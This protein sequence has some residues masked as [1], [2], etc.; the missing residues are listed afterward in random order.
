MLEIFTLGG[1]EYIVNVLN[2]VAAWTGGG[3]FRSLLQVVMVM[4]LTY[5]LIIV[6]FSLNWKAG[7]NWF[8]SATLMYACL[9]V[10]TTS[11][12]VTDKINPSLAPS[13]V[14]NVPIGLAALAS[15]T[16]QFG[17]WM[18]EQAELVFVMPAALSM[19]TN[20]FIYGTQLMEKSKLFTVSD[21]YLRANIVEYN[22]QCLM[23]D[24]LLGQKNI[25]TLAKSN[26]LLTDMGPGSA[27]RAQKWLDPSTGSSII[28]CQ[29][30]YGYI[31]AGMNA[32][33]E[34]GLGKIGQALFPK[35][36]AGDAL[37]K[38]KTDLT[39]TSAAFFGGAQD[40]KGAFN[41]RALAEAFME[42]RAMMGDDTAADSW[43]AL[44]ADV[45]ARNTYQSVGRQAM[46]WVPL[47]QIVLTV[48]F[49][50]MFPVIFPLFLM[51][52]S[53]PTALK[54]Y[55]AGFFYLAAWGP[56]Y[57]VLHMFVTQREIASMMT[58]GA[59][60]L[61]LSNLGGIDAVNNDAATIAGFLM[62]SVPF[63]AA[64]LARGAMAVASN[65]TSMLQPAQSAA[66]ASAIE[67]TTGNYA[68]GNV[69]F[70]N[71]TANTTQANRY[72][73][74]PSYTTGAA[75]SAVRNPEGTWERT[76]SDGQFSNTAFDTSGAMS[77]LPFTV[78][79]G[80]ARSMSARVAAGDSYRTAEAI[81]NVLS[82]STSIAKRRYEGN[83]VVYTDSEGNDLRLTKS[84]SET[85]AE[86]VSKDKVANKS[87]QTGRNISTND[88]VSERE[89]TT[90]T[91]SGGVGARGS[92]GG[93]LPGGGGE[94]GGGVSP[95][96]GQAGAQAN[97]DQQ[98][99]SQTASDS[100]TVSGKGVNTSVNSGTGT[101]VTDGTRVSTD[102]NTTNA[103]GEFSS[104]TKSNSSNSGVELSREERQS[105]QHEQSR[106]LQRAHT[107]D[108]IASMSSD[109]DSRFN[110]NILPLIE[111]QYNDLRNEHPELNLP[112]ISAVR[113]SAVQSEARRDAILNLIDGVIGDNFESFAKEHGLHAQMPDLGVA[114]PS[115]LKGGSGS[116][117][118]GFPDSLRGNGGLADVSIKPGANVDRLHPLMA[119]AVGVVTGV[120]ERLGLPA[121]VIT[122]GN[123][124]R[125]MVG[126]SHYR[127]EGVDFR[128]NN[129]SPTQ[130]RA[131]A[132]AVSAQ[133]GSGYFVQFETFPD[134]PENNHL[135]L[136]LRG[137]R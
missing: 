117:P 10:P 31:V 114:I 44:R 71:L 7:L 3:G 104:H 59:G 41:Q 5:S 91:L 103:S 100:S 120:A 30:A 16:S 99:A 75:V 48:T 17:D 109:K 36:A 110:E 23:Y 28:T 70:Q 106:Q 107:L 65:A 67:Q 84:G 72:E 43:A 11:V 128:G 27:A 102:T 133:L 38:I 126:S 35:M 69:S 57:V 121:T 66:E 125:H 32:E 52:Q 58:V 130:G 116:R 62:M 78:N 60:G 93:K 85:R 112:H 8:L 136:Q 123:D 21:A 51:P 101:N 61:S 46:T 49:Y 132:S 53:G 14:A 9:I 2:A 55:V 108:Q 83:S 50:A 40:A 56:L 19:N 96:Y 122:S 94:G 1:G 88:S 81:G 119:D 82:G 20:G 4:G 73:N 97:I 24:I 118:N 98:W 90:S 42:A 18:T 12:K 92:I 76:Y 68:Y 127:N 37:A 89:S 77:N 137:G 113:I 29:T 15:L 63:L 45:Q 25:N 131:W 135:H 54:G 74:A 64:G 47:L 87:T 124:S 134:N 86:Y 33:A 26:D 129:I 105:L 80:E 111:G 34:I 115:D 13:V 22:K 95:I 39:A 79:L 6:A